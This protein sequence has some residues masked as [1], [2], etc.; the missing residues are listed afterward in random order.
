MLK[1]QLL[2]IALFGITPVANAV[3]PEK[4][5]SFCQI[6]AQNPIVVKA[7]VASTQRFV[8]EDDP[9]GVA[10]WIYHLDVIKDYRHGKP[11]KLAVSSENTTSRVTLETGQEYIVFASWNSEGQLETR[12]YCAPY[13]SRKF[14]KQIEQKVLACLLNEKAGQRN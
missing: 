9:E 6:V 5:V 1:T 12:N 11:E 7:K 2:L 14:D 3:C 10:G 8:D 13:S 4:P